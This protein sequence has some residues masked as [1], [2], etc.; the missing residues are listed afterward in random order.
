MPGRQDSITGR[1]AGKDAGIVATL[2]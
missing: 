2:Y 1:D